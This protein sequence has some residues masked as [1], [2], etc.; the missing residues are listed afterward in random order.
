MSASSSSTTPVDEH[1]HDDEPLQGAARATEALDPE[2]RAQ[3]GLPPAG[4]TIDPGRLPALDE[5]QWVDPE[6]VAARFVLLR[7]NYA[8]DEETAF[9]RAKSSP[10]VVPRFEEDLAASSPGAARLAE[11]RS[12]GV[13][14]VGEVVGL[15][16]SE[17]SGDRSI[18]DLTVRRGTTGDPGPGRI[19]FWRLT[20]VRDARTS[21]WLVAGLAVS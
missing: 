18:V 2:A 11:L 15:I 9:L 12:R 20:L 16:T 17:R 13:V 14:F 5:A 3:L 19:E 4:A 1:R 7:T 6:A 8:I 10:Y 21:H